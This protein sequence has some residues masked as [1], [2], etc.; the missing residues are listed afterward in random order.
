MGSSFERVLSAARESEAGIRGLLLAALAAATLWNAPARADDVLDRTVPFHIVPSPLASALIEFSS[1]SGIQVAAADA[2]V[3]HLKTSGVTGTFTNRAALK[4]LLQDTGLNYSLV[5]AKTVAIRTAP[6]AS[7][8]GALPLASGA[9]APP[10]TPAPSLVQPDPGAVNETPE[11]AGITVTAPRPPTEQELAGD[12]LHQFI[13]HHATVHYDYVNGLTR[14]LNG[15][16][17]GGSHNLARWRGGKQSICPR[18]FGIDSAANSFVTARIRAVAAYVGAPVQ[19]DPNCKDNVRIVFTPDPAAAMN[20][21]VEWASV[22]YRGDRWYAKSARLLEFVS[23]EPI[24]GW[25]LTTPRGSPVSNTDIGLLR[26]YLEPLWPKIMPH[27]LSDDGQMGGIGTVILVVDTSKLGGYSVATIADYAAMLALSVIQSPDHC[28][29][30]PSILDAMSPSCATR[31]KP[32]TM[33]AGDLAFLK[34][35]YSRDWVYGSSPARA[36]I[37]YSMRQQFK[38]H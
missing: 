2:D 20:D 38:G 18:A 17:N 31:E 23:D 37:D 30:L 11:I 4:M 24:Q 25:Y 9:R 27:W 26:T 19:S 33:T 8:L 10:A 16:L 3:S 36:D 28:D 14:D 22:Y 13:V 15:N 1:Q 12:S 21:V 6:A 29:P 35:L 7:V 5:G 32:K 34:A